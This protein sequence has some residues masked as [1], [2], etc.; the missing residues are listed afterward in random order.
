[1]REYGHYELNRFGLEKKGSSLIIKDNGKNI[2]VVECVNLLNW[3]DITIRKL[4][5]E[6][7]ELK[8]AL[9][10]LKEIGDYQEHR[11]EE[12]TKENDKLSKAFHLVHMQS[13]FSTVK[14]FKGNVSERYMY[15]EDNDTIYDTANNY[16]QY[17][18]ILD[19]KEV[20]LLLNEYNALLEKGDVE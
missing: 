15:D 20:V 3:Q 12:L 4:E 9:K 1:M 7:E 8:D 2:T 14:S 17:N 16:G 19:K 10:E 6:N 11:I 13:M 18:N 5:K